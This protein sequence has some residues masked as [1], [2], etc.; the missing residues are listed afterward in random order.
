MK[1][2]NKKIIRLVLAATM[3]A[4]IFTGCS[5]NKSSSSDASAGD[6]DVTT[7]K[8]MASRPVGGAIDK[9]VREIA[10]QYSKEHGGKWKL[11]I[12]TTPDRP[13]YLQKLRTLIAGNQMP[14]IIDIDADPYCKDLV[15]KGMLTD[16]KKYLKDQ[17]FYDKYY[18]TAL[19]YQEFEDG[20]MYTLP[21]EYHEEMIWYNKEIYKKYNLNVPKTMDEFLNNC[22][23]LEQNGVTPISI[24]GIDRWPVQRYIAMIPFRLTGNQYI[25]S[26]SNGKVSMGDQTGMKAIEFTQNVGKYFNKGFATTDYATAQGMFLDGKAAMYYIGDWELQA[27]KEEYTKGEIDY[28]H[29]PMTNDATTK[30]NEFCVNSGIGMAFNAKTFDS[31]TKDF[32]NYLIEN[33]GKLYAEKEQMS[34]IKMDQSLSTQPSDLYKRIKDDMDKTGE[35]FLKP[36]D[37]YLDPATNTVMQD[38]ILPLASGDL[39]ADDFVKLIDTAIAANS[40]K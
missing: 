23:V 3:M 40:K 8:W 1:N 15:Q 19:K 10:D 20:S 30:E 24:D 31:K 38:N 27:M 11:E 32:I 14:D 34:P 9:T 35:N 26:L 7:I 39:K 22:K 12:E 5:T 6:N 21:L 36:W 37:T 18:P 33:Y 4:S 28:F 25:T 17:N 29:L 2:C 16:V 13:A